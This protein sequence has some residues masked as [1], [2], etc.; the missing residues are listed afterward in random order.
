MKAALFIDGTSIGRPRLTLMYDHLTPA[1]HSRKRL[2]A[3]TTM[4]DPTNW[5]ASG[6]KCT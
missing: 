2:D 5:K 4:V 3:P 6:L 1:R